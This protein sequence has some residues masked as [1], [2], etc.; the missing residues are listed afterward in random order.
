MREVPIQTPAIELASF[1][2]WAGIAE[3][4]GQA[5]R[6]IAAGAVSVNGTV[7]TRRARKLRPGDAVA[8]RGKGEF[9]VVG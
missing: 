7:E 5:K 2:K 6:L 8:V 9:R 1:L 4:G 3:T